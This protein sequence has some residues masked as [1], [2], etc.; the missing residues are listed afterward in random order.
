MDNKTCA[1]AIAT[2]DAQLEILKSSM[3]IPMETGEEEDY[4]EEPATKVVGRGRKKRSVPTT[5]K[6]EED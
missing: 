6:P 3:G 4:P 1:A 2:I 5:E